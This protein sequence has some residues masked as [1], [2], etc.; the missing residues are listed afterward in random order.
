MTVSYQ[1]VTKYD[2]SKAY[3]GYTLYGPEALKDVYLV[4]M[5]GRFVHHWRTPY[6]GGL[7]VEL[8]PNGNLLTVQ[9]IPTSPV[10][11]LGG[12]GGQIVELDWDG[13][14]VW[15]YEDLNMNGH[16]FVRMENGNLLYNPWIPMSADISAKVK[17]GI[18]GTERDG[19]MWEDAFREVDPDGKVVWEWLPH[20]HFDFDID[21]VC[22]LCPR[23]LLT[24]VNSLQVLPDGNILTNFR[25]TNTV[26]IIDKG[27]GDIIWRWG[28]GELGH[29]H[30][31]RLL[32]NGNI[33][34]FDNGYHRPSVS[35]GFSFSRVLE[36]S[37]ETKEIKWEYRDVSPT[38]F[39][40][41]I[42][43]SAQRLP[44]GNTLVCHSMIGRLFEVTPEKEIVWEFI[45]PFYG[46]Y[47]DPGRRAMYG[48]NNFVYRAFRYGLDYEGLRGKTLDP[49][50][51]E[52]TLYE[53]GKAP[54]VTEI[55][56]E[57]YNVNR[58]IT[59]LGY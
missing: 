17:G 38:A 14:V 20:E 40:S 18:P 52:W 16:D 46:A 54:A 43:G 35:F 47:P 6:Q 48:F 15:Q 28:P 3:K 12:Y 39:Y 49:D 58:R 53:K 11:D 33:L 42:C 19:V 36:V 27:T 7:Q 23:D 59:R 34:I 25:A 8:L 45:N 13:N 44:N 37:R 41:S 21:I 56:Q 9:R 2:P 24:Y 1:T 55:T 26:A 29:C 4:D 32:D 51:F 10:A 31:P 57:E 30:Y 50:R 5:E 22:P